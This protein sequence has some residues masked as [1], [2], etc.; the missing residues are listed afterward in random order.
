MCIV[1][2]LALTAFG[3]EMTLHSYT[4]RLADWMTELTLIEEAGFDAVA[5]NLGP[6]VYITMQAD[7]INLLLPLAVTAG[8]KRLPIWPT[9]RQLCWGPKSNSSG[10]STCPPSHRFVWA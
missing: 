8:K 1:Q 10:H 9:K 4:Y 2:R 3:T 7:L 6:F 5:L